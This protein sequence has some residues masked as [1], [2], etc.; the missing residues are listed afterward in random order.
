MIRRIAALVITL[1]L[2]IPANPLWND[3]NPVEVYT[4]AEFWKIK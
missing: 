4:I 1:G 2:D 3:G